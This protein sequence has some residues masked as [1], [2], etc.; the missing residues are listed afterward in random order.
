MQDVSRFSRTRVNQIGCHACEWMSLG[1]SLLKILILIKKTLKSLLENQESFDDKCLVYSIGNVRT[2]KF[3][4]MMIRGWPLTFLQQEQLCFLF[5]CIGKMW[6]V[7]FSKNDGV[8]SIYSKWWWPVKLQFDADLIGNLVVISVKCV[9]LP[10][11]INWYRCNNIGI[12]HGYSCINIR[13]VPWKVLKTKAKGRSFQHFPRDL[14]NVNA[15]KN[16]V[17]S[18]LL[19]KNWKLLLHFAFFLLHYLVLPF[20]WCLANAISMDYAHSRAGQYTSRE[21]S[22]SVAPVRVYWKLHSRALTVRELPC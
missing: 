20:H 15:L 13:Q 2:T 11:I 6:K 14:A 18:L 5:I 10:D 8:F 9:Y 17:W 7:I 21:G 4:Q 16:H 22:N 1:V 3:I 12:K 19:H